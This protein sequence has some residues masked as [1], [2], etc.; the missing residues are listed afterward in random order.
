MVAVSEVMTRDPVKLAPADSM[1]RAAELMHAFDV[2]AIPVC[3][4]N[5]LIGMVTDRDVLFRGVSQGK[6][7]HTV[8]SEV[9]TRNVKR[10]YEYDDVEAVR[11]TMQAEQ[12]S[13][14]PVVNGDQ[15]LVG[16]VSL[17]DLV[18]QADNDAGEAPGQMSA[19]SGRAR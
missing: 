10:C 4:S 5:V 3:D 9:Y 7:A 6:S 17:G 8:V 16:I 2:G 14:V 15:E 12:I 13:R 1:Q 19:A 11:E 18:T